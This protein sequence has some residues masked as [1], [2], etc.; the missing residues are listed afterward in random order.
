[1]TAKLND[2]I[3]PSNSI[4]NAI[5]IDKVILQAVPVERH[6][7]CIMELLNIITEKYVKGQQE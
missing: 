7:T 2:S 3:N 6:L 5:S 1:M 4:L